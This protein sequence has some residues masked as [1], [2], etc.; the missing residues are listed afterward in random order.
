MIS[1]DR[2]EEAETAVEILNGL[3]YNQHILHCKLM[4]TIWL[5]S[6]HLGHSKGLQVMIL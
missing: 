5:I 6:D 4:G 1:Y 3:G 2:L